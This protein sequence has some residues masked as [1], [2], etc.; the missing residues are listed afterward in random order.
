MKILDTLLFDRDQ[1]HQLPPSKTK[2]V[3]MGVI[4]L[5]PEEILEDVINYWCYKNLKLM[6][7]NKMNY[8]EYGKILNKITPKTTDIN[9]FHEEISALFKKLI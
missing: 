8:E 9:E 1:I 2:D 7:T 3:L 5:S 6:P 4:D